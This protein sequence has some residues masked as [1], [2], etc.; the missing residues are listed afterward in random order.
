MKALVTGIY[1]QDGTYICKLLKGKGYQVIGIARKPID[2]ENHKFLN[3]GADIY[4]YGDISEPQFIE[5]VIREY[6]PDEIYNLAAQSHVGLS[7][8]APLTT[9]QVNYGGLVN[10][11]DAVKKWCK[12]TKI[13]QAGTSEMYGGFTV[14][15]SFDELTP[16]NPKSPYGISKVAAH[17]AGVNARKEGVWVSNGILFNHES[18][19]RGKDFVTRKITMAAARG[20]K[21]KLGN[22]SSKR[23][24][25]FAGDYVEGMW[26][27]LQFNRPDNFVL[28]TNEV[29][30]VA[31]LIKIAGVEYEIDKDNLRPNDLTYLK[32]DYTK[33]KD[34]LG[35]TPKTDFKTLIEM[36]IS[37]DKER[38]I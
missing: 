17:W 13:Y 4:V 23:D 11:I 9:M 24:W 37:A 19:I 1:G 16:F 25:G 34:L 7:F 36:M 29:H 20:E 3:T 14:A 26:K 18:P 31:D 21:V 12:D 35:W 8:S 6:R 27:M 15:D 5:N 2:S 22:I 30:S 38:L 28:A 33:A 32:G 10:I